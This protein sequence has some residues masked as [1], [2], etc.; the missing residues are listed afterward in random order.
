LSSPAGHGTHLIPSPL[1]T[2]PAS[3]LPSISSCYRSRRFARFLCE[4]ADLHARFCWTAGHADQ[5]RREEGGRMNGAVR[6]CSWASG[7]PRR[8]RK[9]RTEATTNRYFPHSAALL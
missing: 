6:S 9:G 7:R 4:A 5:D 2:S 3:G 8:R 1:H